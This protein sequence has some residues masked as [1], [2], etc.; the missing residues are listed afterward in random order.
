MFNL[1]IRYKIDKT[2]IVFDALSRLQTSIIIIKNKLNV[3]KAL[4]NQSIYNLEMFILLKT[5]RAEIFINFHIILMKMSLDFK[6]HFIVE[7]VKNF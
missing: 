3:L 2:N 6:S 7:Y 4:Y 5:L 1:I